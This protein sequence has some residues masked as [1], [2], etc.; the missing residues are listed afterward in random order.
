MFM[1]AKPETCPICRKPSSQF[2]TPFCSARCKDRDLLNWLGGGYAIPA[3]AYNE[4]GDSGLDSDA[5]P[6]L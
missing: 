3:P 5:E 6:H 1:Q 4:E 2:T